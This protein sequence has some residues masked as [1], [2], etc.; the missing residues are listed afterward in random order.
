MVWDSGLV[1]VGCRCFP[2]SPSGVTCRVIDL[3][4][5]ETYPVNW[6]LPDL[7]DFEVL[8]LF[9]SALNN[10]VVRDFSPAGLLTPGKVK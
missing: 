4:V 5:P 10:K 2:R 7:P 1:E 9:E 6:K 3:S 8:T